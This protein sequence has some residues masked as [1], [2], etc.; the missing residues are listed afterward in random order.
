MT[1]KPVLKITK[2]DVSGFIKKTTAY[3]PLPN[4]YQNKPN[5]NPIINENIQ[6]T[7][8]NIQW[9]KPA[10]HGTVLENNGVVWAHFGVL[11][12]TFG[13]IVDNFGSSNTPKNR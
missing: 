5:S 6:S 8:S 10:Q 11:L 4:A 1:N 12:D 3:W 7:I 13:V 2:I 9:L